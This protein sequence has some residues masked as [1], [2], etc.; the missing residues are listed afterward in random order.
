M[1]A[2]GR[3]ASAHF[4]SFTLGLSEPTLKGEV[5]S[6]RLSALSFSFQGIGRNIV[7]FMGMEVAALSQAKGPVARA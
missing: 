4:A 5:L 2:A 3:Q 6:P 1:I 7:S